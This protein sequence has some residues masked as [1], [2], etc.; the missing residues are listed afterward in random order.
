LLEFIASLEE[1]IASLEKALG[2]K[3]APKKSFLEGLF[4]SEEDEQDGDE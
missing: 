3:A 1:R 2:K 4:S